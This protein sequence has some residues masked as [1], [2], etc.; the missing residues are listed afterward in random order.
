LTAARSVSKSRRAATGGLVFAY[1]R[2]VAA[3]ISETRFSPQ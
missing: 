2:H 1:A 3:L